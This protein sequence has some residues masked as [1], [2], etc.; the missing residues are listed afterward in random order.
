[1]PNFVVART[2]WGLCDKKR[3]IRKKLLTHRNRILT[4]VT[5]TTIPR[6][7]VLEGRT[8]PRYVVNVGDTIEQVL[9]TTSD[10]NSVDTVG[11]VM[12]VGDLFDNVFREV[13]R[14][15]GRYKGPRLCN[16]ST[17]SSVSKS[18]C[19]YTYVNIMMLPSSHSQQIQLVHSAKLGSARPC[20][21][22]S[23]LIAINIW[24]LIVSLPLHLAPPMGLL[25]FHL[26]VLSASKGMRKA[27][28]SFSYRTLPMQGTPPLLSP[29]RHGVQASAIVSTENFP[30]G[31]PLTGWDRMK[32]SHQSTQTTLEL[33]P[34]ALNSS[35]LR[36]TS[37]F[38][39]CLGV[40]DF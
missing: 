25:S 33:P 28:T 24:T 23:F 16:R 8:Q 11:W 38:A 22:S 29:V 36:S 14:R 15:V 35:P 9:Y 5:V 39:R 6:N 21:S 37:V 40:F 3:P 1:M 12:A 32:C 34:L 30:R 7:R 26:R 18:G 13:E 19:T 4:I 2:K 17:L 10:E 20:T 31:S 27:S